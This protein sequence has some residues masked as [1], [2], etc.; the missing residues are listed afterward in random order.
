MP[1][2][3][4]FQGFMGFSEEVTYGTPV[5][6]S[7]F[8]EIISETIKLARAP[9]PKSVLRGASFRNTFQPIKVIA[10]DVLTEF[11]FD[12]QGTLLKHAL[13]AVLTS[14]AGPDFT[15]VITLVTA[16]Q[17]G[18]TIDLARDVQGFQYHGMKTNTLAF[19]AAVDQILRVTYGFIG[20][21]EALISPSTPTFPVEQ[22]AL[23]TSGS[24][25]VDAADTDVDSFSITLDNKIV[26]RSKLFASLTKE[27]VRNERREITGTFTA[28]FEN[29]TLYDKFTAGSQ[30]ALVLIF[31]GATL[32]GSN[33]SLKLELKNVRFNGE[34]PGI[35]GP[36]IIKQV[37]PFSAY[38]DESSGDDALIITLVNAQ[39]TI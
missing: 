6:A 19:E 16:L 12:G 1:V 27:P 21:D 26:P 36:G 23:M 5:V 39:A 4:G 8:I 34:T 35:A 29:T 33:Y 18:L 7:K 22:L 24:F 25:T 38:F 13:G 31:T 3:L 9:I 28:D 17:I 14:G 10:G 30:A 15:H 37:V 2:A 32:G 20:E 11:M